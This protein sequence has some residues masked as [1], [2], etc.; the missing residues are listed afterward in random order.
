MCGVAGFLIDSPKNH[1][2]F[3]LALTDMTDSIIH[4][5]P[6]MQVY[7]TINLTV[8]GSDIADFLFLTLVALVI[9]QWILQMEDLS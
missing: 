3:D 7:G 8:L 1:F 5:G 2:N 9:N 4:R 6:M